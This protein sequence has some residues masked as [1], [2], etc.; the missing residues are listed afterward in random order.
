MCVFVCF[1]VLFVFGELRMCVN[2]CV[3]CLL[4]GAS[5]MVDDLGLLCCCFGVDDGPLYVYR[6]CFLDD[7]LYVCAMSSMR[8]LLLCVVCI[9]CV[10]LL[11]CY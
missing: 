11:S 6:F 3:C 7:V 9:V 5:D 2:C 4:A 8:L 10:L 1:V